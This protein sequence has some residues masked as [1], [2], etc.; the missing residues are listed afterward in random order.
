MWEEVW[1][2]DPQLEISRAGGGGGGKG[3]DWLNMGSW[4]SLTY[5]VIARNQKKGLFT[6]QRSTFYLD[7]FRF[8]VTSCLIDDSQREEVPYQN[9]FNVSPTRYID[10]NC[11]SVKYPSTRLFE[12][13]IDPKSGATWLKLKNRPQQHWFGK[14]SLDKTISYHSLPNLWIVKLER[15]SSCMSRRSSESSPLHLSVRNIVIPFDTTSFRKNS[16]CGPETLNSRGGQSFPTWRHFGPLTCVVIWGEKS[17][18]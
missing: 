15:S 13:D 7:A 5:F 11:S 12:M 18:A 2:F 3:E 6:F 14:T 4:R 1:K 10:C 16:G 8:T 9:S 17:C